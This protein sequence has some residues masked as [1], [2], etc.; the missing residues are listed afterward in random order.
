MPMPR[1]AVATRTRTA[2]PGFSQTAPGQ[3]VPYQ[4]PGGAV[5]QQPTRLNPEPY[6]PTSTPPLTTPQRQNNDVIDAEIVPRSRQIPRTT[7]P[8]TTSP[9]NQR[10]TVQPDGRKS[11]PVLY[12]NMYP[13]YPPPDSG[14]NTTAD[15]QAWQN[16]VSRETIQAEEEAY[17][18]TSDWGKTGGML[19]PFTDKGP[20]TPIISDNFRKANNYRARNGLPA[21]DR[22]GHEQ[23]PA[24]H[25]DTPPASD[26][27]SNPF[28]QPAPKQSPFTPYTPTDNPY[29]F[30]NDPE[31]GLPFTEAQKDGARDTGR[32]PWHIN[33]ETGRPWNDPLDN[34]GTPIPL[35]FDGAPGGG[36]NPGRP[37]LPDPPIGTWTITVVASIN[38]LT[39]QYTIQGSPGDAPGVKQVAPVLSNYTSCNSPGLY[40]S[41]GGFM[42]VYGCFS[43]EPIS[44]T[45]T[46]SGP[47][48]LTPPKGGTDPSFTP[49]GTPTPAPTTPNLTKPQPQPQ[50][51]PQPA[52]DPRLNPT[53]PSPTPTKPNPKPSDHPNTP[54]LNKPQ[55]PP[56]AKPAPQI[57]GQP[58][59]NPGGNPG[60]NP[61]ANP[62]PAR[63]SNPS[64]GTG[65]GT[66]S[67]TPTPPKDPPKDICEEPCIKEMKDRQSEVTIT[68]KIFDSCK[69]DANGNPDYFK[70]KQIKCS[71]SDKE[72]LIEQ[73]ATLAEIQSQQCKKNLAIATVPEWWAVRVGADRPQLV[74]MFRSTDA[75]AS[76]YTLT[77]PHYMDDGKTPKILKYQKGS[78]KCEIELKDNSKIRIYALNEVE[79]K[80]VLALTG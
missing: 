36:F 1:P 57:P 70:T 24:N 44:V 46:Y 18:Y 48:G 4:A 51:Q 9:Q 45:G 5:P 80:R 8:Q 30:S 29:D 10:R 27:Q 49:I 15:W 65:T 40:T 13:A 28:K 56:A 41:G 77:I 53:K 26:F 12:P 54:N 3:M 2:V 22:F 37:D 69:L 61:G 42:P 47:T 19:Y 14:F 31:T 43:H 25:P 6:R 33:P 23:A 35:P 74:I 64:S 72:Q 39:R 7:S 71:K 20:R 79:G 75:N 62:E 50:P 59:Y 60:R 67:N 68:I 73:F 17:A 78:V 16:G 55:P 21:I 32:P 34:P 38:G 11:G 76:R 66:G 52:P 63:P 58:G